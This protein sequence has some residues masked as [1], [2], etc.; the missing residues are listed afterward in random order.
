[1]RTAIDMTGRKIGF[2]TVVGRAPAPNGQGGAYFNCICDCGNTRVARGGS[3]R[4]GQVISC[5]CRAHGKPKWISLHPLYD[6]HKGMLARCGN[7]SSKDFHRYGALG[8]R[9][10]DAW[11][12]IYQFE[13]DMGA[14]PSLKHSIDRIDP[15]GNYEPGNCRW[16]TYTEQAQNRRNSVLPKQ[17]VADACRAAGINPATFLLRV[18]KGMS[19]HDAL[20]TPVRGSHPDITLGHE[21]SKRNPSP[22]PRESGGRSRIR[23]R[24]AS[25]LPHQPTYCN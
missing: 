16:A 24:A 23:L 9:V 13:R 8:V 5:G 7:P 4:K 11:H 25:R 19:I 14:R 3:L 10:C 15:N 17:S 12:D 6:I 20:H 21:G 18:R 2:L 1:M 22:L